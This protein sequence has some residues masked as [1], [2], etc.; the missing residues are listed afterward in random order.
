MLLAHLTPTAQKDRPL[1][2]SLLRSSPEKLVLTRF[3]PLQFVTLSVHD[4][5]KMRLKVKLDASFSQWVELIALLNQEKAKASRVSEVSSLSELTN[6]T[7]ITGSMDIMDIAEFT[8]VQTSHPYTYSDHV[9]G[10]E[11]T[12]FSELTVITDVT[13][14][15]DVPEQEVTEAPDVNIFTEVT[16]VTDLHD[17]TNSSGVR[18]VFENDDILRAKQEEKEKL[19]KCLKPGCLRDT[20]SKNELKEF[21]KQ[22]PSQ[23]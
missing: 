21:T 6:S 20:K 16:E 1:F 17:G 5:E 9:Y 23:T 7:D 11:S 13:D 19:E 2:E 22:S 10:M 15:T 14:V 12:D 8:A 18:V 4:A 3:L